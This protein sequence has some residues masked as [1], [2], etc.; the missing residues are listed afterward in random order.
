MT[1]AKKLKITIIAYVDDAFPGWIRCSFSDAYENIHYITEKV[2]VITIDDL[3]GDDEYPQPGYIRC[4]VVKTKGG[5]ITV[6]ISRPFS[7]EDE[8]G[9]I[10]FDVFANQLRE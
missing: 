6:D 9:K 1:A 10:I 4:E 7:I 8:D 2:P 3:T 5:I